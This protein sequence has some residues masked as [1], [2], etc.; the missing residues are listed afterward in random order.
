[1]RFGPTPHYD[2]TRE[3]VYGGTEQTWQRVC[4]RRVLDK[5]GLNMLDN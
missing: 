3:F 1:L 5:T 4:A 2:P